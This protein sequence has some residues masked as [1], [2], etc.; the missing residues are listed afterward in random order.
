MASKSPKPAIKNRKKTRSKVGLSLA[1]KSNHGCYSKITD[2]AAD[3]LTSLKKYVMCAIEPTE[4]QLKTWLK[5]SCLTKERPEIKR[6]Y[7]KTKTLQ[8]E[9][10]LDLLFPNI[11][12]LSTTTKQ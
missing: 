12:A 5:E 6:I 2:P 11:E 9:I 7:G 3:A 10:K 1:T 4:K 8:H